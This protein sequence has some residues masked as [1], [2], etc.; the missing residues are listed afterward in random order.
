MDLKPFLKKHRSNERRPYAQADLAPPGAAQAWKERLKGWGY[1]AHILSVEGGEG[2][3]GVFQELSGKTTVVAGPSGAGKSSLINR[4]RND[5]VRLSGATSAD[6]VSGSGD[7]V[8]DGER[9]FW[10]PMG[11]STGGSVEVDGGA[12]V[13]SGRADNEGRGLDTRLGKDESLAVSAVSAKSGLG[14]HTTRS[15][16]LIR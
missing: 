7:D 9:D 4:L 12:A 5:S 13:S 10:G 2:L 14:R 15:I 3:E 16:V 11:D 8:S 6:D 1:N